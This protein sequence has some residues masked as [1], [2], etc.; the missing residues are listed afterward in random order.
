MKIDIS[1]HDG[2]TITIKESDLDLLIKELCR[3]RDRSPEEKAESYGLSQTIILSDDEFDIDF[4]R[5]I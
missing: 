4:E 1:I 2:L 5:G 3:I